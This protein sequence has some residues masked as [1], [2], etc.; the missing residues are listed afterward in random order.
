VRTSRDRALV[1]G[2]LGL[3]LALEPSAGVL[4]FL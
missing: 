1:A 4:K 2:T 3:I